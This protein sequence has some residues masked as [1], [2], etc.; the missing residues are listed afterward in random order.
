[1]KRWRHL[2]VAVGMIP[3]F[4]LYITLIMVLTDYLTNIH[5]VI[6]LLFYLVAGLAWI[7]ASVKI[8]GWLA[9][10]EAEE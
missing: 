5:F 1:M 9:K 8:I 2:L 10:H 3:A 7:P 6:D 4:L